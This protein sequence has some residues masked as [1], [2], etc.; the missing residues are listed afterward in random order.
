MCLTVT[1]RVLLSASACVLLPCNHNDYPT[2]YHANISL[3]DTP[4]SVSK[5]IQSPKFVPDFQH[6]FLGREESVSLILN[7][8]FWDLVLR[9]VTLA[10]RTIIGILFDDQFIVCAIIGIEPFSRTGWVTLQL[11]KG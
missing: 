4:L 9:R 3:S 10:S 8:A 6:T 2:M 1:G 5:E 11:R 7:H